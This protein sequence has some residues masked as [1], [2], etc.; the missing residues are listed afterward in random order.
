MA[1]VLSV[2]V[3]LLAGYHSLEVICSIC[4]H[5]VSITVVGDYKFSNPTSSSLFILLKVDRHEYQRID[6][7]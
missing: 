3:A 5:K 7:H 1:L 4:T 2:L 6:C